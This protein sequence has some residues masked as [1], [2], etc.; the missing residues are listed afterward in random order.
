VQGADDGRTSHARR[1][2]RIGV[3]GF[4]LTSS[5]DADAPHLRFSSWAFVRQIPRSNFA[6]FSACLATL[7]FASQLAAPYFA[8]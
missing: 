6:R 5:H 7:N 8:I 2:R 1:Q 4:R 3:A